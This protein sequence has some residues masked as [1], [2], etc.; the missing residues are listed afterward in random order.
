MKELLGNQITIQPAMQSGYT[1]ALLVVLVVLQLVACGGGSGG[2]D[3][4]SS[5]S[6]DRAI[7]GQTSM[8]NAG[9]SP[10]ENT[11]SATGSTDEGV[12]PE[13]ANTGSISLRWAAPVTRSDGTPLSLAEIDGFYIYYGTSTD[14]YPN[15]VK[16]QDGSAQ[17]VILHDLSAGTY[18]IV[19]TTYDV[20]GYES[21]YSRVVQKA[22]L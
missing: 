9:S 13:D 21:G 4:A 17:E 12:A 8:A 5:G 6:N 16:L 2:D 15:R 10:G 7:S 20:N 22:V 1:R 3:A 19:M 18:Y 11:D 14:N